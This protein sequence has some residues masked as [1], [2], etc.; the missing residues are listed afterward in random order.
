MFEASLYSMDDLYTSAWIDMLMCIPGVSETKAVCIIKNYP[1]IQSLIEV[2]ETTKDKESLLTDIECFKN[3]DV[4]KKRKLG[5]V[6][7]GK[8]AKI[9][10]SFDPDEFL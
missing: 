8:I 2:L 10:T 6:L 3:G 9:F 7:S 4:L 5:K 1:T